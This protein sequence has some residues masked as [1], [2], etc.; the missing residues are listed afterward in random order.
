MKYY[1]KLYQDD[2]GALMDISC[3]EVNEEKAEYIRDHLI[4]FC[5]R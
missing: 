4:P 1:L 5:M 2:N 3:V